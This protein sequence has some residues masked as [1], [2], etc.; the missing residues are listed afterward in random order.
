MD[1][2]RD[3][4]HPAEVAS[5]GRPAE[6]GIEAGR[7]ALDGD[8]DLDTEVWDDS[9]VLDDEDSSERDAAADAEA[10]R[11]VEALLDSIAE[12][13]D[14][15]EDEAATAADGRRTVNVAPRLRPR[16]M[17]STVPP[18]SSTRR[19]TSVNPMPRPPCA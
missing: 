10:I 1:D 3:V 13:G 9:A 4:R 2:V 8:D 14:A 15:E 12:D 5:G 19:R 18:C 11:E 17:A 6:V 7:L 16:L